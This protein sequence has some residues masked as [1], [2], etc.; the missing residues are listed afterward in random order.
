MKEFIIFITYWDG[1]SRSVKSE[2]MP[3]PS[4]SIF[5]QGMAHWWR[6]SPCWRI[7]DKDSSSSVMDSG[8]GERG[9][10]EG[11]EWKSTGYWVRVGKT[12]FKFSLRRSQQRH[13]TK[14]SAQ[15]LKKKD[16]GMKVPGL[17]VWTCVTAWLGRWACVLDC[18]SHQRLWGTGEAPC[19]CGKWSFPSEA[20]Q[21]QPL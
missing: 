18:T 11:Q 1:V 16:L 2:K 14:T 4:F 21:V 12:V 6:F 17:A 10:G 7:P 5:P 20:F 3:T 19:L 8:F 15:G 9:R 13:L